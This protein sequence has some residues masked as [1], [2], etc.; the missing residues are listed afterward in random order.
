M[1]ETGGPTQDFVSDWPPQP[2]PSDGYRKALE[3]L[4]GV[5]GRPWEEL[6]SLYTVYLLGEDTEEGSKDAL[7]RRYPSPQVSLR[8]KDPHRIKIKVTLSSLG[9]GQSG[10]SQSYGLPKIYTIEMPA[11]ATVRNM[12]ETVSFVHSAAAGVGLLPEHLTLLNPEYKDR[13]WL[14]AGKAKLRQG[15]EMDEGMEL[16]NIPGFGRAGMDEYHEFVQ[17]GYWWSFDRTKSVDRGV[18]VLRYNGVMKEEGKPGKQKLRGGALREARRLAAQRA[19]IPAELVP[20]QGSFAP[21]TKIGGRAYNWFNSVPRRIRQ[22]YRVPAFRGAGVEEPD[23][24]DQPADAEGIRNLL[25][26]MGLR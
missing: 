4:V 2:I 5:M 15:S 3:A 1:P 7:G 21:L 24:G 17:D 10:E 26:E 23:D 18:A 12:K 9:K 14:D 20:A 19:G 22:N 8:R 11:D 16:A 25:A 6:E 13:T